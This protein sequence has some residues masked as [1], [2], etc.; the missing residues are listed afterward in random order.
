M[1][2]YGVMFM[3]I[4]QVIINIGMCLKLLPVIGI[5]LPFISSGG[6]SVISLYLAVGL[7]L[8]VYR[9]S[10]SIGYDNDFRFSRIARNV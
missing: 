9:S 8:S 4:A 7:V 2:C 5:T 6:S 3:I 1:L 10:G